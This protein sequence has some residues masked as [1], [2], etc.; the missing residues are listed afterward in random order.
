MA[1]VIAAGWIAQGPRV[2]EFE[3]EFAEAVHGVHAIATSSGA[4]ALHLALVVAGVGRGDDVVVPSLG[5]IATAHAASHVG[6]RVVFA[7]VELATGCVTA[8]T[9]ARAL[10]PRTRAVIAVDQGGVPVDLAPIR[11]LCDPR[12]IVVIE[13]AA[14]GVGST[15]RGEPLGAGAE[16]A[17]WSFRQGE[18]LTTGEGGMLTTGRADWAEHAR[19]LRQHGSALSDAERETARIP[20]HEIH[21][22]I[23]FGFRMTDLQAAIGLVQL[24]RLPAIVARRRAAA[25]RYR[26]ALADVPGIRVVADPPYGQSAFPSLWIEIG[27]PCPLNREELLALL[28][29]RG[30]SARRGSVAAHR[31]PAYAFRDT[32]SASLAVTDRLADRTVILPLFHELTSADQDR[33]IAA[34]RDGAIGIRS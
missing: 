19:I 12:G 31:Q 6:A 34:V 13:D 5:F 32:G 15:Y 27:P 1:E 25:A 29:E 7:D 4:T 8:A 28:A 22:E 23:G 3:R 11:A 24:G 30:I 2:A 26:V 18:I 21:D 9:I 16:L 10:T 20:P 33:V 17:T 14:S